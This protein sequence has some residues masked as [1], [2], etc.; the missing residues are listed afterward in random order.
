MKRSI[1][2]I[3]EEEYNFLLC[4]ATAR[5]RKKIERLID[6]EDSQKMV[7][8][9]TDRYDKAEEHD[10]NARALMKVIDV[11]YKISTK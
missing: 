6:L 10:F 7:C 4:K 8:E 1:N 2:T 5:M 3:P 11:L 9:N